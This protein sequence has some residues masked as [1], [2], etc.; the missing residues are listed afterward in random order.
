MTH[1]RVAVSIPNILTLLRIVL[2]PLIVW[3]IAQGEMGLALAAFV[4]A[5]VTDA[6]D[7]WIAKTFDMKTE[8]GAYLDPLADKALIVSIYVSL[9][10]FG[11]LPAWVAILV[12]S[13]DIMIV[14]GVVLSYVIGNPLTIKPLLVSKANTAAQIILAALVL[15]AKGLGLALDPVIMV[16]MGAVAILTLASAGA[17]LIAF[18]RHMA[19]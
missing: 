10:I 3:A 19:S 11:F 9:A 15:A 7:G 12:V 1:R 17:Y 6:L 4:I 18:A 8:L 14:S 13:R 16:A 2:V 5:G